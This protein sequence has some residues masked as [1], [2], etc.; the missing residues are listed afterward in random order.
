MC[1]DV[2]V[3]V[4]SMVEGFQLMSIVYW[5]WLKRGYSPS[6]S[7]RAK[8]IHIHTD[9]YG[10]AVILTLLVWKCCQQM[11]IYLVYSY[12]SKLLLSL[13][14]YKQQQITHIYVNVWLWDEYRC[15]SNFGYV[16]YIPLC[17]CCCFLAFHLFFSVDVVV[18]WFYNE[19]PAM[20]IALIWYRWLIHTHCNARSHCFDR[21]LTASQT[22]RVFDEA[23]TLINGI[24]TKTTTTTTKN[25]STLFFFLFLRFSLILG[26]ICS[27][28]QHGA[29]WH[30]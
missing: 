7:C 8:Q 16:V 21:A 18:F 20:P 14:E 23:S 29:W 12:N 13:T 26:H 25:M 17:C 30:S 11:W 15:Y 9:V 2:S 1:E 10:M 3:C 5:I 6:I 22:F 27:R 28:R 19:F 24:H 4:Y